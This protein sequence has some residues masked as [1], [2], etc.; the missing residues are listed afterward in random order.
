MNFKNVPMD[1]NSLAAQK[2][3]LS[4]FLPHVASNLYDFHCGTKKIFKEF[5]TITIMKAA[6]FQDSLFR[7]R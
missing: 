6:G 2:L 1:M 5:V 7:R 3:K 4:K